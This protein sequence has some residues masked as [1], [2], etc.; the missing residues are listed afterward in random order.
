MG[1]I[2]PEA[3]KQMLSSEAIEGID[4]DLTSEIQ[5]CNSCEYAKVT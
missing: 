5:Q 2:A 1:H 3:A 4:I